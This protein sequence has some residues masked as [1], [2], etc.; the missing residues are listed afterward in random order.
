LLLRQLNILSLQAVAVAQTMALA[1]LVD[2]AQPQAFQYQ[3]AL[4]LR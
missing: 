2:F 1:A 4:Q 3:P